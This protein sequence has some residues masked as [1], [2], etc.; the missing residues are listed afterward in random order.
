MAIYTSAYTQQEIDAGIRKSLNIQKVYLEQNSGNLTSSMMQDQ[1]KVYVISYDYTISGSLTVPS[2]CAL[3]FAGG[4]INGGTLVLD[5]TYLYGNIKFGTGITVSGTCR[6][7]TAYQKWFSGNNVDAWHR[8]IN[9]TDGVSCFAYTFGIYTPTVYVSKEVDNKGFVTIKGNGATLMFAY[10]QSARAITI[11]PKNSDTYT[12]ASITQSAPKG[13]TE[14]HVSN[15]SSFSV[16]DTI[17]VRD[18]TDYSF[19]P[20]RSTYRHCEFANISAI[21]GDTITVDHPLYGT[22]S[23]TG[24]I[25]VYGFNAITC[26]IENLTIAVSNPSDVTASFI[27]IAVH[28][29]F[30]GKMEN[31][32]VRDFRTNIILY[33]C[34]RTT[35]CG[36]SSKVTNIQASGN[37]SYGLSVSGCQNI[38]IVGGE[39]VGGNH[40]VSIGG[41]NN[42]ISV[43]SRE[44]IV[45]NVR[46]KSIKEGFPCAIDMHGCAEFVTIEGCETAGV[47]LRGKNNQV[48]NNFIYES[49]ITCGELASFNH[50]ISGNLL[51]TP[52][53]VITGSD[54]ENA[55]GWI[56]DCTDD[57]FVVSGN[58]TFDSA[59]TVDG[60]TRKGELSMFV[61]SQ[62]ASD[63]YNLENTT[64][65][66]ENNNIRNGLLFLSGFTKVIIKGN[67]FSYDT[68][69]NTT[70]S[71]KPKTACTKLFVEDNKFFGYGHNPYN[72]SDETTKTWAF[73]NITADYVHI[74]NNSVES[75]NAD[76]ALIW[77]TD[78]MTELV[79]EGN[80]VKDK[81]FIAQNTIAKAV[82]KDNV[83][84]PSVH[85]VNISSGTDSLIDKAMV[86]NNLVTAEKSITVWATNTVY[87]RNVNMG[88][89]ALQAPKMLAGATSTNLD[90]IGGTYAGTTYDV[91]TSSYNGNTAGIVTIDGTKPVTVIAITGDVTSLELASGKSPE[92]GHSAHVIL[93]SSS[94]RS[95]KIVHNSNSCV[96]PEASD[97]SLKVPAG[98]YVEVDFISANGKIYARGV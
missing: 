59:Y 16:G 93:S 54:I 87:G 72:T 26:N 25:N 91:S 53:I 37:D 42:S 28:Q 41:A 73:N 34:G 51:K 5:D 36:C 83:I 69:L 75:V 96:C 98:G 65:V 30:G 4:S 19:S 13:S 64:L 84:E 14:I 57:T 92:S 67:T 46:A 18:N 3:E 45:K 38:N 88:T 82:I 81:F 90:S 11:K 24:N 23:H 61:S 76:T 35:V 15:A 94:S 79:I 10:T 40:A 7:D 20:H 39:Y 44:I 80:V 8:F 58:S 17:A 78:P 63:Y 27:G 1:N 31:V 52:K 71:S 43:V 77:S 62:I 49:N 21:S 55:S 22:Y 60:S 74:R 47:Y 85:G 68:S 50:R 12:S 97:L 9:N 29:S 56:K 33:S 95:I 89:M 86:F 48:I 70:I 66:L 32:K 6:N 2:G